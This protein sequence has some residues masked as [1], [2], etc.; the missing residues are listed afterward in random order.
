MSSRPNPRRGHD[1]I[2]DHGPGYESH[3]P[4]AGCNSTHV[5]RSR[6]KWKRRANR[7]ER[8]TGEVHPEVMLTTR[9]RPSLDVETDDMSVGGVSA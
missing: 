2:Q 1:R 9:V 7:K 4:A 8:R 3:T 6:A 5:A